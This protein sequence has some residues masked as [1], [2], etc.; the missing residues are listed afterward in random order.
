MFR[1][2][3]ARLTYSLQPSFLES[4]ASSVLVVR[5]IP[6]PR[7]IIVPP[8]CRA[9]KAPVN[10]LRRFV[11]TLLPNC[12]DVTQLQSPV[13]THAPLIARIGL[14]LH[15]LVCSWCRRYGKNVKTLRRLVHDHP[16]SHEAAV[17]AP[18]SDEA[19]RR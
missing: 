1:G 4:A 9:A 5:L 14:G 7:L 6:L 12:R 2:L 11:R 19:R 18:L 13:H 8:E 10:A 3:V 15:L 17:P 16:K